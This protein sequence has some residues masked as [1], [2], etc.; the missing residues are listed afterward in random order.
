[1]TWLILFGYS[2]STQASA[3]RANRSAAAASNFGGASAAVT[4]RGHRS[5]SAKRKD[6]IVLSN[7]SHRRKGATEQHRFTQ[8]K[9]ADFSHLC[10]IRVNL[11]LSPDFV[12][13]Q[14]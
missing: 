3:R 4:A 9:K 12:F 6:F 7:V 11:W 1:M 8:M 5:R 10:L 14:G 2:L 13:S